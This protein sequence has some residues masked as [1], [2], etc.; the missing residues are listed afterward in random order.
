MEKSFSREFENFSKSYSNLKKAYLNHYPPES[1]FEMTGLIAY[2]QISFE[3][4][5]K[6]LRDLLIYLGVY[7]KKLNSPR[8]ILKN[9]Y[10]N[11]IILN[12]KDWLDAK[13]GW[14]L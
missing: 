1:D 7:K 13:I 14:M 8:T 12:E 2:F 6:L 5:W 3:Q 4:A 10:S 9:A 11:E